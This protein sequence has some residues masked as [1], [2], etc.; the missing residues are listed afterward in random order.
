MTLRDTTIKYPPV[1]GRTLVLLDLS[2]LVVPFSNV[3]IVSVIGLG[4]VVL[5]V[6]A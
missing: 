5:S 3:I 6:E 4:C 2:T 1:K